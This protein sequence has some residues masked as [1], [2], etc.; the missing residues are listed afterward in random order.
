MERREDAEAYFS[1][2]CDAGVA[3][4]VHY[5]EPP[6]LSFCDAALLSQGRLAAGVM[7]DGCE[8]LPSV[9]R[10][11]AHMEKHQVARDEHT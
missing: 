4:A 6:R 2:V 5:G 10:W 3:S 11:M 8:D 9:Q 7:L 1:A